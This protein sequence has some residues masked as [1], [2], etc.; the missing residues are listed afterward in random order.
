M[1]DV[2]PPPVIPDLQP[3]NWIDLDKLG[4]NPLL[5]YIKF[6]GIAVGLSLW[7]NWRGCGAKGEVA[8]H[9]NS[10]LDV[11]LAGGY[12]PERG[13]PALVPNDLLKQLDQG[14]GFYSYAVGSAGDPNIRGPESLRVFCY[15]GKRPDQSSSL[16]VPHIKEAHDLALNPDAVSSMGA[17]GVVPPYRAMSMGDKVTFIFQGYFQGTPDPAYR[18]TKV[19][20]A[21]DLG[22]ALTFTVP[23]IEIV[24]IAGEYADISYRIEY[25]DGAGSPSDS[26]VQSLDIVQRASPLL[27]PIIAKD[28]TGGPINPGHYPNGLMLRVHPVYAGLKE[29][30]WVLVYWTG[31]E[32][33]KSVIKALRV[34]R[35]TVDSGVIECLIEPHWLTVN[36]NS[37]VTVNYQFAREGAA[38]S[39]ETLTL[40][41]SK[42]LYLP[43]PIVEGATAESGS[44]GYLPAS[45]SGAYVNVSDTAEVGSGKIELHW[46]G[47][48][49]GG[50]H[51]ALNPVGGNDKRYLIPATAIAANMSTLEQARFPVFYRVFPP[52]DTVG[53]DS[54]HFNLRITPLPATRYPFTTSPQI[55]DNR[56]SLF[57]VPIGGADLE[58]HSSPPIDAWPFM[59]Q[60]QLLTMEVSGVTQSGSSTSTVVRNAL[61]VTADEM[62]NKKVTA[63]LPKAFLN[64]LRLNETFTLK[65]RVSFNGG[66]T[67]IAFRDST[68]TL[69]A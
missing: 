25:A 63:K 18:E 10:R 21:E 54:E 32:K 23:Y 33:A 38:Q 48:P 49:N 39:A 30:D 65:A 44:N 56:M 8:D 58:L 66:E 51:I 26:A 59:A 47:H 16:P 2:N 3:G 62:R 14:F 29:G 69:V 52:G 9:S 40:N 36:S 7:P 6:P 55:V 12:T 15:I 45:T 53:E 31:S 20:R 24:G 57:A 22:Q 11:T 67:Y 41:I 19:L 1:A 27:P 64:T 46:Q 35:S 5:T 68:P 61:P 17:T 50:R 37:Q 28:Y 4:N 34:D 60:G 13:M 42:P 43:P